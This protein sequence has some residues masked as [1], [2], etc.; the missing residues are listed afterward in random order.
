MK[1]FSKLLHPAGI[2]LVFVGGFAVWQHFRIVAL[3][4]SISALRFGQASGVEG[5]AERA[6]GPGSGP[7]AGSGLG[8][9]GGAASAGG[10]AGS[11][12]AGDRGPEAGADG[13]N[14]RAARMRQL[15]SM[16]RAQRL[17]AKVLDLTSSLNLTADQQSVVRAALEN[18]SGERDAMRA[19]AME[20]RRSGQ[21]GTDAAWRTEF[22][23]YAASEAAEEEKIAAALSAEQLTEYSEYITKQKQDSVESRA[24]QQLGD[25][26]GRFTL[27]EEQKDAAFQFFAQQ[28]E[29]NA[30][31]RT[32]DTAAAAG[33]AEDSAK[34]FEERQTARLEA[35]RKIL[36][37]AQ[38]ELL[39]VQED[40][41]A[42]LFRTVN[43]TEPPPPSSA[44][45]PGADGIGAP[46]LSPPP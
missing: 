12:G 33:S 10:G 14:S 31:L 34:V 20:R 17:E 22:S 6:A 21:S 39:R 16:D 1:P 13:G 35:M 30:A 37:P 8:L 15:R 38:F 3:E 46:P 25:L 19:A 36:T 2:A 4:E 40:Q 23:K 45:P 18:G 9:P 28:E 26:Q 24:N 5:E 11:A 27:T 43:P 44:T 32:Q 29:Q 7:G 41:R 42:A